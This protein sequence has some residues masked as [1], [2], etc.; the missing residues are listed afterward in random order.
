MNHWKTICNLELADG[1]S[2]TMEQYPF[3]DKRESRLRHKG[4]IIPLWGYQWVITRSTLISRVEELFT[5]PIEVHHHSDLLYKPWDSETRGH[6]FIF[7]QYSYLCYFS[8]SFRS[9]KFSSWSII[10]SFPVSTPVYLT[11]SSSV[12]DLFRFLVSTPDI[13]FI[14]STP[15]FTPISQIVSHSARF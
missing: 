2:N 12:P 13:S 11:L 7:H 14:H 5:S 6:S 1:K 10:L 8:H 15:S 9:L 3:Y 4:W